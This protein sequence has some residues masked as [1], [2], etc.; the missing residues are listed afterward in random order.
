MRIIL[1][2]CV[3]VFFLHFFKLILN[4]LNLRLHLFVWVFKF[5]IVFIN[6][7][8]L[9]IEFLNIRLIRANIIFNLFKKILNVIFLPMRHFGF[10]IYIFFLNLTILFLKFTVTFFC[11]YKWFILCLTSN[12]KHVSF[13][14][15]SILSK[16]IFRF[17]Y[18]F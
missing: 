18:I 8:N 5:W 16:E 3:L 2:L 1:I 9:R 17:L 6:F 12:I 10:Q 14:L 11:P 4:Y 15:I 13:L 7:L